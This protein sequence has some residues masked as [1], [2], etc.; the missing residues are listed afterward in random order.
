MANLAETLNATLTFVFTTW[1]QIVTD[2]AR[3]RFDIGI[4]GI[5]TTLERRRSVG[6]SAPYLSEG[7][8]LVA[9]CDAQRFWAALRLAGQ[10]ASA[11][12]LARLEAGWVALRRLSR[13]VSEPTEL[14]LAVNVGG[15]NERV[16]RDELE[17]RTREARARARVAGRLIA[18]LALVENN[19]E[20]FERVARGEVNATVTDLTE[21]R[22]QQMRSGGALCHGALL[23]EGTKAYM[24]PRDDLAWVNYVD[25][26]LARRLSSSSGRHCGAV[27]PTLANSSAQ[28]LLENRECWLGAA[29]ASLQLWLKRSS[30]STP[31]QMR[32]DWCVRARYEE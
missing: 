16:I 11:F 21:A 23:T 12:P 4:G 19:G 27:T 32:A 15:T 30:L 5:S 20:Q 28:N 22:L 25:A 24:L 29:N 26:W 13:E 18:G 9:R 14:R 7:K 8:V 3:G 31:G 1:S 2:Q 10:D 17:D 6:F